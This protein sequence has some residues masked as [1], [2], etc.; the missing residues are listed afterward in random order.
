MKNNFALSYI[1]GAIILTIL[2]SLT[3]WHLARL[4]PAFNDGVRIVL[5]VVAAVS[6][7]LILI[8]QKREAFGLWLFVY[9]LIGLGGVLAW[10]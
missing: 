3:L 1:T 5:L 10:T 7:A 8:T 2:G 6:A 4:I 9:F